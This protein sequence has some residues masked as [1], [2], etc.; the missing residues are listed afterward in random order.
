MAVTYLNEYTPIKWYP[1]SWDHYIQLG[2]GV[3][4]YGET[5]MVRTEHIH[6]GSEIKIGVLCEKCGKLLETRFDLIVRKGAVCQSCAHVIDH[7]GVRYGMIVVVRNAGRDKSGKMYWLCRCDC[8]KEIVRRAD[9][10]NKAKMPS[11]GCNRMNAVVTAL[12]R[13]TGSNHPMWRDDLTTD[14]R[15]HRTEH[16][17]GDA[18]FTRWSYLVKEFYEFS[19]VACNESTS[20][21]M[22]SHHLYGWSHY[23]QYR[24]SVWNGVCLCR[25]CHASFHHDYGRSNNTR[26]QFYQWMNKR[27]SRLT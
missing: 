27:K 11:C 14:E 12:H 4:G 25:N 9:Q 1:K 3:H 22:V 8:G 20:G 16:R 7:T 10:L 23:C 21:D 19:C 5:V 13:R 15:E 17:N 18:R 26:E 2:Y 6:P 24:Y